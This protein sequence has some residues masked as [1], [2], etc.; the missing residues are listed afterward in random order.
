MNGYFTCNGKIKQSI[1]AVVKLF[2]RVST[3]L[4]R[5][6]TR[7]NAVPISFDAPEKYKFLEKIFGFIQ[8]YL[9]IYS[10]T[11][12]DYIICSMP[13]GEKTLWLL[14]FVY[15][16][17]AHLFMNKKKIKITSEALKVFIQHEIFHSV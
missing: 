8:L 13:D 14:A 15:F 5:K 16:M 9:L 6:H 11:N 12:F 10:D 17:H 4:C 7:V 2:M 1:M 3:A